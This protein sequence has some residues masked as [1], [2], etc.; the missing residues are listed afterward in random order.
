M[1]TKIVLASS[2]P[3]RIELMKLIAEDFEQISPDVNEDIYNDLMPKEKAMLLAKDKCSK[4][5]E[6]VND[7]NKVIISCDTVVE[8]NGEIFEKPKDENETIEMISKF[9]NGVHLVHTAV[10]ISYQNR[11][12]KVLVTTKIFMDEIPTDIIKEYA[13]T[14]EPYDK[15]GGY[16]IQGTIG[17]YVKKIHGNYHNVVGFPVQSIMKLFKFLQIKTNK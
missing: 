2:S 4:A 17:K 8:Y 11:Y 16:A 6:I 1:N 3:R 7:K 13:K 9:S 14:S 15:A 10:C 5:T 12:S